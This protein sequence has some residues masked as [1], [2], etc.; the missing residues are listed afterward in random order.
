MVSQIF[1]L[2]YSNHK[3]TFCKPY[4]LFH[5]VFMI[6]ITSPNDSRIELYRNLHGTPRTHSEAKIFIAEGTKTTRALL[7]SSIEIVSI[8]ALTEFYNDYSELIKERK[9][10]EQQLFTADKSIMNEIVGFRLHQGIMAIG[11]QPQ[12]KPIEE[13]TFPVV[14]LCGIINSENVG[15]IIRNC[16]A[17][18]IRSVI[19]DSST[20]SPYLRRAVRV[21]MGAVFGVAIYIVKDLLKV[22]LRLKLEFNASIISAEISENSKYINEFTFPKNAIVIFG[23]EGNGIDMDIL[24][25]SDAVVSIPIQPDIDSLNVAAASAIILYQLSRDI[26]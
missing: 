9:L 25:A 6:S 7:K 8:F 17:F 4:S 16:A 2:L 22:L 14:A 10:I 12:P 26:H 13:I 23:N 19:V 15:V 21:S 24:R 11:I 20:S 3:S 1:A 5:A 18:G